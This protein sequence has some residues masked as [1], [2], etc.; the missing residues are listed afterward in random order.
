MGLQLQ[1]LRDPVLQPFGASP[2]AESNTESPLQ[3][4]I[5]FGK[6]LFI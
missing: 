5:E 2:R 4:D 1:S 3:Y 6:G